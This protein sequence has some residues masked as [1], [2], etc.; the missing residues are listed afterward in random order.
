MSKRLIVTADDFGRSLE[1][2]RAVEDGHANGILTAASLMVTEGAVDDAVERARR[3]PGLGV[4]LHVTLVD[5]IPALAP[6]QIP[7]LVDGNGLFTL[8]LVRLGTR[9]FLSKAAQRQVSAEMRTQFELFKA[10]GLPLAHVDFHHHYHQHPTVFALVLDLAVEYGAPGIRIPWEP[11]LLSYRAR[12]DRL[13]TRLSNGLFHWRRNRAMA[14]KAKAR[15]LV[16][17]ERAFGLNDSGQMDAAKV[18]SFLGVLPEGLSEIY[19]HPATAHWSGARPM[20]PHYRIDDE[21]KALIAP[22]N[23][24]KVEELGIT[25]TTFAAEARGQ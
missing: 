2:N 3:L 1:I 16:V 10:T 24:R 14:A 8:D 13:G 17:N 12:G 25:L 6:S 18:N 21:Y 23:R 4:G 19:C 22:E 20:P 9:I 11:P 7:D 15:G 5:G